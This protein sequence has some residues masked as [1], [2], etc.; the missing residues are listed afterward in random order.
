[1]FPFLPLRSCCPCT[2]ARLSSLAQPVFAEVCLLL[3]FLELMSALPK[4]LLGVK[5]GFKIAFMYIRLFFPHIL[6]VPE[7]RFVPDISYP[8]IHIG[9]IRILE[10]IIIKKKRLK[11]EAGAYEDV[12]PG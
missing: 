4:R 9:A 6:H 2:R 11:G 1:M 12:R 7:L 3:V 8:T 10:I 5:I